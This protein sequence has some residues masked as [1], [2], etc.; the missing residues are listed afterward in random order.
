MN[1]NDGSGRVRIKAVA[2]HVA[3]HGFV[4]GS[5]SEVSAKTG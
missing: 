5:P 2:T 1:A 4:I 3:Y